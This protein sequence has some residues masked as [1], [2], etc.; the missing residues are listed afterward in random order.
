[1]FPLEF[2]SNEGP[3]QYLDF[4]IGSKE[5]ETIKVAYAAAST[6]SL[7]IT[8]VDLRKEASTAITKLDNAITYVSKQRARLGAQQNRLESALSVN[9]VA[10][11]SLSASRSRI[12]DADY[13]VETAEL[14][15][16]QILQQAATAMMSQAQANSNLAL[17]LLSQF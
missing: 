12:K 4:Q 16:S 6:K 13:A 1:V 3:T 17:Q 10:V 14:T 9:E 5:G 8:N 15:K 2:Y 7:G 11:E